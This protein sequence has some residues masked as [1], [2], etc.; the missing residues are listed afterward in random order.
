MFNIIKNSVWV[1]PPVLMNPPE[2]LEKKRLKPVM[3][4]L[5]KNSVQDREGKAEQ[6]TDFL[7]QHS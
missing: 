2:R 6:L 4:K 7:Q 3:M 1:H 5:L